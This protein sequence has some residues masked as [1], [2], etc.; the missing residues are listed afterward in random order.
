MNVLKKK[1]KKAHLMEIQVNGGSIGQ[2]VDFAVRHFEKSVPVS[3]VFAEDEII[4]VIGVTRGR[5][6]KGVTSRWHT[7]KLPRKTHKGLRKVACIG[8]W[9]PSRVAFTVARAGQKGFHHRTELNKKVYR[10]GKGIHTKDGKVVK[11]NAA[12]DYDMTDKSITPMVS[13]SLISLFFICVDDDS[14]YVYK[15]ICLTN[16]C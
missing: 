10:I 6:Y 9:H 2:K 7:K 5:G 3:G 1:Q 8:A 16:S 15:T 13:L 14:R 12:T 4:D 11:N